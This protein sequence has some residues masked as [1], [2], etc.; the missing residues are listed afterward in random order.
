M[1]VINNPNNPTGSTIPKSVLKEIVAFAKE[2]DIIIFS[3]EVYSPLYHSLPVEHED[4]PSVLA[5]GYEKSVATGSMS[6]AF[7]LAGIRTGWIASRD[8]SIIKAVAAAR[9]YTTISV[10][11]LDDQVASYALSEPVLGPLLKR[12]RQRAQINLGMLSAFVQGHAEVC[13]WVKPTAGTTALV[14]FKRAGVLVDDPSFV[15]DVLEK[16]K[17]L[18]MPASPCF[19]LGKD[20]KGSVRI[21]YVCETEVLVDAL[22]KLGWYINDH[23]KAP[24][25]N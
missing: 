14:Q 4:P 10:S 11:Q 6:K 9:D 2:R 20:F 1:I 21:G 16:T 5:L 25:S 17:V 19:G 23:L 7:A 24:V 15:L 13:S 18:F 3:D 8:K 22:A 12:N